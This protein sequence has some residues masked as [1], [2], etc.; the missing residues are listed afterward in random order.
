MTKDAFSHWW[1]ISLKSD[2]FKTE[3]FMIFVTP[4]AMQFIKIRNI[5]YTICKLQRTCIH[6]CNQTS[7]CISF[8]VTLNILLYSVHRLFTVSRHCCGIN[9]SFRFISNN[10]L[11]VGTLSWVAATSSSLLTFARNFFPMTSDSILYGRGYC[12]RGSLLI[13]QV[14]CQTN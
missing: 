7:H 3:Q 2:M 11:S 12:D 8:V 4:Q 1:T 13:A 10:C 14:R 9:T 6:H 5:L